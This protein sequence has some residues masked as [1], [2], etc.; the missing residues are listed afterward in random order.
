MRLDGGVDPD[1][2]AI[3]CE[4]AFRTVAPARLVAQLDV[5]P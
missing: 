4:E 1:E 5:R 2:V 3:Q